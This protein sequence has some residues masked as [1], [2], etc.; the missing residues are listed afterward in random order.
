[1]CVFNVYDFVFPIRFHFNIVKVCVSY[2]VIMTVVLAT[3]SFKHLSN[4]HS[5]I[6]FN[7]CESCTLEME[8]A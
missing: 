2:T 4:T 5:L 8:H 3:L 6:K 1:M 7:E